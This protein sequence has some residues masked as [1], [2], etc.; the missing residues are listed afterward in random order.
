[1]GALNP[2]TSLVAIVATAA[3]LTIL[4]RCL[5]YFQ[6]VDGIDMHEGDW[7]HITLLVSSDE[8]NIIAA[9]YE[10]HGKTTVAL[11]EGSLDTYTP[12]RFKLE[13]GRPVVFSAKESHASY[14]CKGTETRINGFANDIMDDGTRWD[15]VNRVIDINDNQILLRINSLRWEDL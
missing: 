13:N 2:F 15:T 1:M 12:R 3:T 4:T 5:K 14:V 9:N 11:P 7:E 6:E 10:A 8:T